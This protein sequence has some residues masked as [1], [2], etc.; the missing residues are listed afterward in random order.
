MARRQETENSEFVRVREA[1]L[2]VIY[3]RRTDRAEAGSDRRCWSVLGRPTLKTANPS[4]AR[5]PHTDQLRQ[6]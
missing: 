1:L 4:R 5:N 6:K 3:A 2:A